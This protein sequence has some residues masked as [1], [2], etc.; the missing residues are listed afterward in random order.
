MSLLLDA[1][2]TLELDAALERHLSSCAEGRREDFAALTA[3]LKAATEAGRFDE[4]AAV[5]RRA[6]LPALPV[7][8]RWRR[9]LTASNRAIE[10]G[11]SWSRK[12]A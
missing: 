9:K 1:E 2:A 8:R 12:G 10:D 3:A 4:A 11:S 5:L 7:P 6:A